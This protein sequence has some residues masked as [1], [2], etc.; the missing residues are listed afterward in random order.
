MCIYTYNIY[1]YTCCGAGTSCAHTAAYVSIR[2]HTSAYVSA[3]YTGRIE[4]VSTCT[5]MSAPA[6]Q[7]RRASKR[8]T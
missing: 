2:Q 7:E 5:H 1:I 4:P 3:L 6:C 8:V